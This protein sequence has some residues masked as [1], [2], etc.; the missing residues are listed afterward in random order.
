MAAVSII[1]PVYNA[2]AYLER[3]IDSILSQSCP[4][5]EVLLIDDGST[6]SSFKICQRFA[7]RDERVLIHRQENGG[8]GSAR[9]TG[10]ELARGKFLMFAD[11]D[12]VLPPDAVSIL[13]DAMERTDA[14]LAVGEY[15][16]VIGPHRI[17]K[18]LLPEYDFL[19]MQ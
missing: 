13:L 2:E 6:D 14:D 7:E 12:D 10:M 16:R 4:D 8:E 3:C 15:T 5:I 19:S 9:N 1:V 11:N 17:R 18:R